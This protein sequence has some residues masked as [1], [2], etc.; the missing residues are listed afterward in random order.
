MDGPLCIWCIDPKNLVMYYCLSGF[1][2]ASIK[3]NTQSKNFITQ[4]YI[5]IL[6]FAKRLRLKQVKAYSGQG[7]LRE[8]KY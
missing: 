7:N 2:I 5:F 6:H 4:N 8:M 3:N 1:L